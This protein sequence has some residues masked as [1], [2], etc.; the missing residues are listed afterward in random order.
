LIANLAGKTNTTS[1]RINREG[2][3]L[4]QKPIGGLLLE[5]DEGDTYNADPVP[6]EPVPEVK[7]TCLQVSQ[8]NEHCAVI[9]LQRELKQGGISIST[10]EEIFLSPSPV[11]DWRMTVHSRGCDYR[12][13]VSYSPGG[14]GN[15]RWTQTAA[16]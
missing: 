2:C 7:T 13:R 10:S 11:V 16:S 9:H 1:L 14:C 12:L 3:W 4:N 6:F 8:A 15:I 5:K